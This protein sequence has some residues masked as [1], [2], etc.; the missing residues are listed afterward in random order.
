MTKLIAV[1][2]LS[3]RHGAVQAIDRVSFDVAAGEIFGLL[4]PNGAGKTTTL[5]CILG[6]TKPDQGG[7]AI[8]GFDIRQAPRQAREKI[9]AVLQATGLQ[10][11]ITPREALQLFASFYPAPTGAGMLLERF[12]LTQKA[13]AAFETL[14]GGQQQ[15]LALALAF[16]GDPPVFLLDEP[17]AGLD[18]QIRREVQTHIRA[19]RDMGRSVLLSTH[20]MA[21]A[22]RLCDRIAVI[23]QGRIVAMG[24]PGELI[25]GTDGNLEDL[26]IRLARR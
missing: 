21:E 11:K 24:T 1:E 22:E 9:G 14:S 2:N 20:D 4:G 18:P 3:R 25:A 6:L 26:I 12:G 10:D 8:C 16:V 23:A 13:D 5:E 7:I 19:M 15:R 17:T